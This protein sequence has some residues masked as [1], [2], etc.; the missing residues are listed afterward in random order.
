MPG[1][2][3]IGLFTDFS[4]RGLAVTWIIIASHS[5][6]LMYAGRNLVQQS[7]QQEMY[8]LKFSTVS[9]NQSILSRNNNVLLRSAVRVRSFCFKKGYFREIIF[10]FSGFHLL[11]T[12]VF[13]YFLPLASF[14][15]NSFHLSLLSFSHPLFLP[16]FR[17][18]F[19]PVFCSCSTTPISSLAHLTVPITYAYI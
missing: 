12:T 16:S 1:G 3:P 15:N 18:Y 2:W 8:D 4:F 6:W 10:P 7:V 19:S 9:I 14:I 13:P 5:W 11:K 17:L